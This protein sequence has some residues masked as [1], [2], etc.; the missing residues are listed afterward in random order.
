MSITQDF[1]VAMIIIWAVALYWS[2]KRLIFILPSLAGIAMFTFALVFNTWLPTVLVF[3]V[4]GMSGPYLARRIR[5]E[6]DGD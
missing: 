4:C 1:G 6:E 2:P 5:D 3:V